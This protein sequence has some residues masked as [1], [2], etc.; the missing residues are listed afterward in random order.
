MKK[1]L[2][3][4]VVINSLIFSANAQIERKHDIPKTSQEGSDGMGMKQNHMRMGKMN[5]TDA[6]KEQMKTIQMDYKTK[7]QDL[8]K[9]D[10][11]NVKDYQT[12]KEMLMQDRR[13]KMAA[14]LTPEQKAQMQSVKQDMQ[15]GNRSDRKANM[16][17]LGLTKDQLGQLKSQKQEM[18]VK[19]E[20][21]KNNQSL[22]TDERQAQMKAL[23]E[24]NRESLKTVLTPEQMK[25]LETEKTNK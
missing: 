5:F 9:N 23:K 2:I 4:L 13:S 18:K 10:N 16:K 15:K 24:S 1:I 3:S 12:Q 11:M 17:E 6:Q 19:M 7:M 8:E 14:L 21:I 22:T 20:S 25:K